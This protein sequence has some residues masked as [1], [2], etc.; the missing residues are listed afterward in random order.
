M[1]KLLHFHYVMY[2]IL[3]TKEILLLEQLSKVYN[4]VT[5]FEVRAI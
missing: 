5:L 1:H 2:K 4:M 3:I